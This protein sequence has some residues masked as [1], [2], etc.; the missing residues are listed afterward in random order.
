MN[1][2]LYHTTEENHRLEW[3]EAFGRETIETVVAFS[4][5]SG[6][7]ILIGVDK[8][9]RAKGLSVTDETIKE[10]V[11]QIK[12][13]TQP[14]IFPEIRP[15]EMD[16][17]TVVALKVQ[18]YP[19]KPVGYKGKYFKR[20]GASNHLVPLDEI[21]EMQ[22]YSI[23]SSFDSFP[24]RETLSDLD[25]DLVKKFFGQLGNTGRVTL[26]DDPLVNLKK[27]GLLKEGQLTFAALLLF[28]EHRTGIHIGRFKTQD[29]I[30]DDILI[31]SP[32]AIAVDEAMNFIKKNI[33]LRY[34]FTGELR[35]KEIW[36]FPLPVIRE[37]LLN[38]VIHKDYRNPTDIM[39][40]IFDNSIQ[41]VNPGGL[42]GGLNPEDLMKGNY[43]AM[44]RNK[45]LAE[46]FYLRGDIEKFGTGFFRIQT[47]L[48]DSPEVS[49]KLESLSGFTRSFLEVVSQLVP[50]RREDTHQ[51]THLDAAQDTA[52]DAA[53]DTAQVRDL[54]M[55]I[56][57]EMNREEIQIKL[58]LKHRENFRKLYLKPA[59]DA[60]WIEMTIPDK[61]NSK[62]QKY[63]LTEKG[64]KIKQNRG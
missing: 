48:K 18:E 3:K 10:W 55:N 53:Q 62:Y 6:G 12:Q 43:I 42:M 54:I 26:N 60:G 58:N 49:L 14:Q 56:E 22:L 29:V 20:V 23:N 17:K 21:V 51:D 30:I 37:L 34:E 11:N 35:R 45:L 36:Q 59:L 15:V 19:V 33:S 27:M 41:F 28:G 39:I 4:N 57:G 16:G 9:G 13:A 52:Q 2:G 47:A 31:N 46:A 5:A 50:T 7:T 24:V 38:A 61:P 8:T 25:M 44:H 32:L 1:N 40:K 64:K 63:R